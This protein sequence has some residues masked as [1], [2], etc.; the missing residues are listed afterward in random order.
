[1][2]KLAQRRVIGTPGQVGVRLERLG[3]GMLNLANPVNERRIRAVQLPIEAGR[4]M[5]VMRRL[6]SKYVIVACGFRKQAF[7]ELLDFS[8]QVILT[9]SRVI[10]CGEHILSQAP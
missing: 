9:D 6:A 10:A 7:Q 2:L 4:H 1:M 8:V 3:Y 5:R